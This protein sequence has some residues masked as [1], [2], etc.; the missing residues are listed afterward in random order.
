MPIRK[1]VLSKLMRPKLKGMSPRGRLFDRLDAERS[2]PVTWISGPPGA[3][4]TTALGGWIESRQ[5]PVLWYQVDSGDADVATFFY[6]L[7][8]AVPKR[9]RLLPLLTPEYLPAVDAFSHRFFRELFSRMAPGTVL[10]LDNVHEIPADSEFHRVVAIGSD[11]APEGMSIVCASR[12][13]PPPPFVKVSM[14]GRMA[15]ID[16]SELRL[17]PSE[18]RAIATSRTSL[19]EADIET[20]VKRTDGW[21]A[22]VVLMLSGAAR[23]CDAAHAGIDGATPEAV[24]DYLG[25]QV[26]R[27]LPP[28]SLTALMRIA[29]L[30]RMTVRGATAIGRFPDAEA[31]LESLFRRQLFTDRR[32]VPS[33]P[34]ARQVVYQFHGLFREFLLTRGRATFGE[35]EYQLLLRE[36]ARLLA[37]EGETQDALASSFAARDW[38]S[39]IVLI[40]EHA[41][42][43]LSQGRRE[44]LV[45]AIGE[46]PPECV[47]KDPWLQFWLGSAVGQMRPSDG[48]GHL[49]AAA[50]GFEARGD[51]TG[52]AV[53][54]A[55]ILHALFL[56]RVDFPEMHVWLPRLEPYLSEAG[57]FSSPSI[58]LL[59]NSGFQIAAMIV[60]PDHRRL[61]EVC[62]RAAAGIRDDSIDP[63]RRVHCASLLI[64]YF[65][66]AGYPSV[67]T[68]LSGTVDALLG[69]P[70]V[71]PL[72]CAAWHVFRGLHFNCL[73][74]VEEAERSFETAR[75]IAKENGFH[76]LEFMA[77]QFHGYL[78]LRGGSE[79]LG[80]QLV[81]YMATH[82]NRHEPES[83]MSFHA[84]AMYLALRRSRPEEAAFHA[85]ECMLHAERGQSPFF[86]LTF[87][88]MA[89]GGFAYAGEIPRAA[90]LVEAIRRTAHG[91]CYSAYDALL[92]VHEAY[93]A[94]RSG[95]R[96]LCRER[97]STA[98]TLA[99]TRPETA[100]FVRWAYSALTELFQ[101]A[102]DAGIEVPFVQECIRRFNVLPPARD[103]RDWP[104]PVRLYCLGRFEIVPRGRP[105]E[106]GRK[107]PRKLFAIVKALLSS[108][109]LS[110]PESTLIDLLWPEQ[111]GDRG[112][113]ALTSALHRVRFLL[114]DS[115]AVRH[116]SGLVSLN[117]ATCWVDRIAFEQY[118]NSDD[119]ER[120]G[121]AVRLY[122]GD[123]LS[124]DPDF[125]DADS[126]RGKLRTRFVEVVLRL[127]RHAQT[128][129]D[130]VEA[131]ALFR[132]GLEIDGDLPALR[133]GV[134]A[135]QAALNRRID[136]I[137][138]DT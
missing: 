24:F 7:G 41:E 52:A 90:Q 84:N 2:K 4:K 9:K 105:L 113:D 107:A 78:C 38:E 133:E 131:L 124:T 62:L 11:E 126:M 79:A 15:V 39:A 72:A 121:D 116:S 47:E 28:Q 22:G 119:P 106:S 20:I 65:L 50:N 101:E 63:N 74:E 120:W 29:V 53:A 91:T 134:A 34:D 76:Q 103:V 71:T 128:R 83:A 55:S 58:E 68:Q 104:W 23:S 54:I 69:A 49:E 8:I 67:A 57:S 73:V 17:S 123:F 109:G 132:R 3:G 94:L 114:G 31:L 108:P 135:C 56:G 60:A 100:L 1:S 35:A 6:Y 70:G 16:W 112:Y 14:A 61:H 36:G 25:D 98:L 5:I 117:G 33:G 66:F 96:S 40:R 95:D 10:V 110:M 136:D 85:S 127:A 130:R 92:D 26:F 118:C 18:V 21:A 51:R 32:Y 64:Q 80:A 75:S 59:V 46:L 93:I 89:V 102:L 77:C 37:A 129:G 30:P 42:T 87:G 138:V 82:V 99:R 45:Q 86:F 88:V 111:D 48:I 137:Q 122:S 115:S 27:T 19:T 81:D 44:T 97:L 12:L 13:P 43:L 125:R